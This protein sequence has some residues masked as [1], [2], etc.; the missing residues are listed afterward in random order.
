MNT[1]S[2]RD[3]WPVFYVAFVII[4][5]DGQ[6]IMS[7]KEKP[8]IALD[9]DGTITSHIDFWL[10]FI[11]SAEAAGFQV[12]IVT[13]RYPHEKDSMDPR[14]LDACPWVVT[15]ERQAKAEFCSRF[16]IHPNIWID[17]QPF[18]LY[19]D[20]QGAVKR[21]AESRSPLVHDIGAEVR[22]NVQVVDEPETDTDGGAPD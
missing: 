18:F 6:D 1:V 4:T 10:G 20:A 12:C 11:K 2:N 9:Y 15:T 7:D 22:A 13:M 17:D 16:G 3:A 14:V 8:L 5:K 21:P 19:L